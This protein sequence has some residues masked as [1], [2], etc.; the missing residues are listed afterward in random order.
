VDV[1]RTVQAAG[2][3]VTRTS[4]NGAFEVLVVHRPR[5]DDWSLP[6]GKLEPGETHEEA[7]RREVAEETGVVGE[8]GAELMTC[9]YIDR[10]GRPKVV[11]WW[12]MTPV[13]AVAWVP[14]AEIDQ[15][16]WIS[17]REAATLLSYEDD[18]RLVAAV[19]GV[20]GGAR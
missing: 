1:T 19:A 7:A 8:L 17:A 16:R 9:E 5:Y 14:N 15:T 10:R 11:R 2:G 20:D 18:R 13:D 4:A 6:K 12:A 3:V